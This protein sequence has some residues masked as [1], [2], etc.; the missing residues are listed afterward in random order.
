MN[1]NNKD[2]ILLISLIILIIILPLVIFITKQKQDIR[3]KA[4]TKLPSLSLLAPDVSSLTPEQQFSVRLFLDPQGKKISGF[5]AYLTYPKEVVDIVGEPTID[6]SFPTLLMSK[7]AENSIDLAAGIA[8]DDFKPV[9]NPGTIA[10]INFKVKA[11]PPTDVNSIPIAFR[12]EPS[13]LTEVDNGNN[14]LGSIRDLTIPLVTSTQ[15]APKISFKIKFRSVNKDI[16][17]QQITVKVRQGNIFKEYGGVSA[18]HAGNGVYN[19][20]D[21]LLSDIT[22]GEAKIFV[23]GPKH[24]AKGFKAELK[25]GE[26]PLFDWTKDELEPGDLP[27]QDGKINAADISKLINLLSV[28]KPTQEN[29]NTGDLNYDGVIN[30]ADINEL[31]LTLSTKYDEDKY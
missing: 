6:E 16:S 24:L 2:K 1:L 25:T 22:T 18:V 29:L 28:S 14:V 8:I 27:P 19:I 7:I 10:T 23:K 30:G 21:L 4:V 17:P 26:V 11:N 5:E 13:I 9:E 15:Q 3:S 31:I 12:E 20:S